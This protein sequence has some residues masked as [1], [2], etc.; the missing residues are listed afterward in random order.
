MTDTDTIAEPDAPMNAPIECRASTLVG[1]D[2]PKRIVEVVA[3]PYDRE[4]FAELNGHVFRESVSPSAFVGV[5]KRANRVKVN[6]DHDPY[7][8]VGRAVTLHPSRTEGLVAELR[9]SRT[10]LGDETLTLCE[11]GDLDP[12]VEFIVMPRGEEWTEHRSKRRLT[13][14][15]LKAIGLVPE[16]AY[17]EV[18]GQVVAVRSA[19]TQPPP[20]ASATPNLDRLRLRQLCEKFGVESPV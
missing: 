3:M 17:G 5:E 18:G 6:R 2:V 16:G 12:S 4:A 11:D 13:R 20:G 7:R 8:H 10:P 19:M 15:Y 9:M 14:L 1:V